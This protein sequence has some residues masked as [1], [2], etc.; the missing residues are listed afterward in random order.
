M[1]ASLRNITYLCPNEYLQKNFIYHKMI[2][3]VILI[4]HTVILIMI[5]KRVFRGP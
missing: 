3:Y 4:H 2:L 1:Q 5:G